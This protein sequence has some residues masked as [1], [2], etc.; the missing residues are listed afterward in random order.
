MGEMRTVNASDAGFV[1]TRFDALLS[2]ARKYSL[3][4]Y[5]FVTACCATS[6]CLHWEGTAGAV[7]L[8]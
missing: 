8:W 4:Q 2:W 1:T 6:I 5:P 7:D 3:F